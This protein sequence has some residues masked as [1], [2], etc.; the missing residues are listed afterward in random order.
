MWAP[1]HVIRLDLRQRVPPL[2]TGAYLVAALLLIGA[3]VLLIQFGD[4]PGGLNQD[5]ASI[6]YDA[7][8]LLHYGIDRNGVHFPVYLISWGSGQNALYAYLSMPVI[9]LAGLTVWSVRFVNLVVGLASLPLFFLLARRASD[10]HTAVWALFLL[11]ISP[12]H[13]M[14]SRWALES[15][16]FPPIFLAAV[17]LMAYSRQGN[18]LL[19]ASMVLFA[20]S[21]YAYATSYVVVPVF[22]ACALPYL[23]IYRHALPR[24]VAWACA[25]FLLVSIPIATF[26]AVNY[27]RLSP[28]DSPLLS[29]PRLTTPRVGDIALFGGN[30]VATIQNDARNF[31]DLMWTQNDGLA[32]NCIPPYGFIYPLSLPFALAGLIRA[33]LKLGRCRRYDPKSLIVFWLLS[34]VVF[35]LIDDVNINRINIIFFPL[36]FFTAEG[37]SL[38]C[39]Y[40]RRLHVS[41]LI[42]AAYCV[43]ACLFLRQYFVYYPPAIGAQFFDS[44]GQALVYADRLPSREVAVTDSVNMPYI[45]V[46]FYTRTNPHQFVREVTYANPGDPY[47]IVRSFG[48]YVFGHPEVRPAPGVVYVVPNGELPTATL[49]RASVRSFTLYSVVYWPGRTAG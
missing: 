45:Y 6:G 37:V 2:H 35:G 15:N 11:A 21:L 22:L 27:Y 36:I 3:A 40:L 17:V 8:A 44:F 33:V 10:R 7:F 1:L 38:A 46:L 4:V 42:A 19:A 47:Q 18:R 25:A 24:Q 13:I 20:V 49:P 32:W 39:T 12:W 16:L 14:A 31:F 29:I 9:A 30:E 34:A 48:K 26:L 5:E 41:V 43:A 28:I 23:V